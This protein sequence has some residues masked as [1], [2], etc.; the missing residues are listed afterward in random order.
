MTKNKDLSIEDILSK[1]LSDI[2]YILETNH[3]Y[4]A[5]IILSLHSEHVIN[6]L[7][8]QNFNHDLDNDRTLGQ[9][10]KLKFLHGSK[11]IA[12]SE[13]K[14]LNCLRDARNDVVHD[15][16]IN[17]DELDKTLDKA[18]INY[19]NDY[20]KEVMEKIYPKRLKF[21]HACVA[22]I[23][24]LISKAYNIPRGLSIGTKEGHY[25]LVVN[26]KPISEKDWINMSRDEKDNLE[27]VFKGELVK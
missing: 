21:I 2:N 17:L 24:F 3:L 25:V 26:G 14:V 5:I 1:F 10:V 12:D 19:F 4:L 16:N 15:L 18:E 8:K 6:K 20:T 9:S 27:E 11:I 22:K 7:I 23:F 13:Y